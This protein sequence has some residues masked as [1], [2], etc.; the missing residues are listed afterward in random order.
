MWVEFSLHLLIFLL[1]YRKTLCFSFLKWTLPF[2]FK[3]NVNKKYLS[4]FQLRIWSDIYTISACFYEEIS[5]F[6]IRP[7]SY[8]V[9]LH[10]IL[11]INHKYLL[12]T[13]SESYLFITHNNNHFLY[14]YI[15]QYWQSYA[16]RL[17][18]F[19]CV[20]FEQ[21]RSYTSNRTFKLMNG[22]SLSYARQSKRKQES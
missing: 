19:F 12:R 5:L 1:F 3:K 13:P 6:S 10:W 7:I 9:C 15:F 21:F 17:S 4:F 22:T 2:T 18:V 16:W 11:R 14:V 8:L 20:V